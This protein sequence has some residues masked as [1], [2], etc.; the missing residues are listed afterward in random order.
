MTPATASKRFS[1]HRLEK[2]LPI[3]EK[4]PL[5]RVHLSQRS[6]FRHEFQRDPSKSSYAN[7]RAYRAHQMTHRDVPMQPQGVFHLARFLAQAPQFLPEGFSGLR[8]AEFNIASENTYDAGERFEA[9]LDHFGIPITSSIFT[10]GDSPI[11]RVNVRK[12]DV[13]FSGSTYGYD[14]DENRVPAVQVLPLELHAEDKFDQIALVWDWDA[15]LAHQGSEAIFQSGGLAAFEEFER[16]NRRNPMRKGP[17]AALF[18]SAMILRALFEESKQDSPF[19]N[20]I[21]TARGDSA[22]RRIRATLPLWRANA[23]F[24]IDIDD[25]SAV[26]GGHKGDYLLAMT[27][28]ALKSNGRRQHPILLDDHRGNATKA[29]AAGFPGLVVPSTV[30]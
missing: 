18:S 28:D 6:S 15:T 9:T 3:L 4:R 19:I 27:Q 10:S 29:V 2:L 1:P 17:V 14:D 23:P 5:F 26:T 22:A 11:E 16:L 21:L 7:L 25:F 20:V 8:I 12:G 24:E 30:R 13:F